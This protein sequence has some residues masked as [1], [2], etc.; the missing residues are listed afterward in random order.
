[1]GFLKVPS[2]SFFIGIL[3]KGEELIWAHCVPN[4]VAYAIGKQ[5]SCIYFLNY[6]FEKN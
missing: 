2:T 4:R 1:M 6:F 5:S 3:L